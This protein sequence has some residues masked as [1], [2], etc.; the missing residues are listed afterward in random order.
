MAE[1]E[2]SGVQNVWL[3][4]IALGLGVIVVVIYNVHIYRVR[5]EGRGQTI[6][7]IRVTRDMEPGDKI[8]AE[9]LVVKLVPKQ[10]ES[11]LGNVVDA[12][13]L[14]FAIGNTVNQGI[15]KDQWLLWGHITNVDKSRP[16][17]VIS[18]GN[19]AV[20]VPLESSMVPGDILR[21]NDRVNIVGHLPSGEAVKTYRIMEGVRVLAIG[22]QGLEPARSIS[23]PPKRQAGMRSYRNITIEV[24][25]TVSI[26]LANVLTHVAGRCW[27]ELLSSNESKK[28]TYGRINPQLKD[29]AAVPG[30]PTRGGSEGT[31]S[32]E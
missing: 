16:A 20:T 19:V 31:E 18:R 10:Y 25:P 11:S 8:A 2:R 29:L 7:L 12:D 3:L 13:N 5:Q 30:R 23:G 27:V 14:D 15:E 22:G 26:E 28:P 6:R 1:E 21:H 4:L 32:W 9:D 17:N 24:S